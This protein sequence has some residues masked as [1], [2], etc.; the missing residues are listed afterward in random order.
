VLGGVFLSVF[1]IAGGT[2]TFIFFHMHRDATL[3]HITNTQPGEL[4]G[5]FWVH[6]ITFGVA[7]LMGLLTTLFPSVTDFVSSWLM[8]GVQALK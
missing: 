4:G 6:V 8:P 3:S 1:A 5:Q 7:P 2:V